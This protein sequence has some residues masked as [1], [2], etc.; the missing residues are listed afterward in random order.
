MRPLFLLPLALV[1]SACTFSPVYF[2]ADD[3]RL[4]AEVQTPQGPLVFD[5]NP[6]QDALGQGQPLTYKAWEDTFSCP[7]RDGRATLTLALIEP[8]DEYKTAYADKEQ[9]GFPPRRE[10]VDLL[11]KS[12]LGLN[13][14][15]Q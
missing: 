8:L 11:R 7:S 14:V 1:L 15:V 5:C 2:R 9:P 3:A 6:V 4:S 10:S 12:W 13:H